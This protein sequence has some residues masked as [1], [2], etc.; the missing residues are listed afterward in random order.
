MLH[1]MI[2]LRLHSHVTFV[3]RVNFLRLMNSGPGFCRVGADLSESTADLT[4]VCIGGILKWTL[5]MIFVIESSLVDISLVKIV[6]F[7]VVFC[8]LSERFW[9]SYIGGFVHCY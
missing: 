6:F 7:L 9:I 1:M 5:D 8:S 3:K 2:C 4:T